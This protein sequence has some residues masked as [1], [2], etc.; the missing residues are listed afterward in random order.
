VEIQRTQ[1]ATSFR[2][3]PTLSSA[4]NAPMAQVQLPLFPHG[5]TAIK[6]QLAFERQ[7]D[8]VVYF[9]GHLPVFTHRTEDL[10]SFRLFTTQLILNGTASQGQIVRAFGVVLSTVKRYCR[11]Y[12]QQGAAAFFKPR[13]RRRGHRLTPERLAEAQGLLDQGWRVP[14]ISQR[15]NILPT[16]LHKAL[17]SGRLR[18]FNKE[19]HASAGPAP[20]ASTK[21]QRSVVNE[22]P[23][24]GDGHLPGGG[25]AV[26]VD[27]PIGW[28]AVAV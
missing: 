9:H 23:P 4:D 20:E 7:A 19:I 22:G 27:G 8:Q 18:A 1:N 6:D 16:T 15:L 28:G 24:L 5:S 14:Q 26:G 13:A 2:P 25:A 17:D 21:S 10:A 11:V 3:C 12:R